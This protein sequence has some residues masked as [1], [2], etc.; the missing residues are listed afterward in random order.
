M[1]ISCLRIFF[2]LNRGFIHQLN[3]TY[4][5]NLLTKILFDP[6][7]AFVPWRLIIYVINEN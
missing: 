4:L 1:N 6:I 7:R 3:L 5:I 2:G